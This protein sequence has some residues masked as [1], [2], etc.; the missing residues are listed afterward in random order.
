[1]TTNEHV[2]TPF[3]QI[4]TSILRPVPLPQTPQ[5]RYCTTA[6]LRRYRSLP[7]LIA[8]EIAEEYREAG[9]DLDA[10]Q[11]EDIAN[12]FRRRLRREVGR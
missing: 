1:M 10:S 12:E 6:E 5:P 3:R 7:K 4:L 11:V 2:A 8:Q 9:H